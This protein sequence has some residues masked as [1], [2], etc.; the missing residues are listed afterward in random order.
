MKKIF[1]NARLWVELSTLLIVSSVGLIVYADLAPEEIVVEV[2]NNIYELADEQGFAVK[3]II[4]WNTWITIMRNDKYDYHY[5]TKNSGDPYNTNWN[6]SKYAGWWWSNDN[7]ENWY[8]PNPTNFDERQ[9]PCDTW[10]HVPSAWEWS[11]LLVS[12]CSL[13][14]TNC[15]PNTDLSYSD[16]NTFYDGKLARIASGSPSPEFQ[17][18]F[19]L[20]YPEWSSSLIHHEWN[21]PEEDYAYILSYSDGIW[22]SQNMSFNSAA[23]WLATS[24]YNVRC[25]RNEVLYPYYVLTFNGN[26]WTPTTASL[27]VTGGTILNL[28]GSEYKATKQW[29]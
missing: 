16:N 19:N 11:K 18:T 25:M 8:S 28:S 2:P 4:F 14:S 3:T 23:T 9:W 21:N 20:Y 6:D 22:W 17:Q 27:N 26:G 7:Y 13:E 5:G 29:F 12:W 10:Y 24:T 1:S 15:N